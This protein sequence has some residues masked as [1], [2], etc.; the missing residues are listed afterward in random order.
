MAADKRSAH[1]P[2][3]DGLR[4][5][6][7]LIVM[8]YHFT[9]FGGMEPI[10]WTGHVWQALAGVGWTGVDL[11][12]V[13]SGFLITG[14]L[15]DTKGS[16]GYFRIFYIRRTLRIFPLYYGTLALFYIVLPGLAPGIA[17][18]QGAGDEQLW[19]WLYLSNLQIATQG[20]GGTS[21][22]LA[23]FWSL[24]VEEQFYLFWPF[25]VLLLSRRGLMRLCGAIV[26]L[27]LLLRTAF[28]ITGYELAAYVLTPARMD[29]L[30]IGAWIAL[31]F[32]DQRDRARMVSRARSTAALATLALVLMFAWRG[33]AKYHDAV[34]GTLGFT[35]LAL[36]YGSLLVLACV[37][38]RLAKV[39]EVKP[40]RFFGRYSYALYVFHQPIVLEVV[41]AGVSVAAFPVILGSRV[42]AQLTF[43]ALGIA[44]STGLALLSWSL[45]ESPFLRLKKRFNY[46]VARH[47]IGHEQARAAGVP[48]A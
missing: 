21:A 9:I 39:F 30:A 41:A 22:H 6:A 19:N 18:A 46:S 47:S 13:L 45:L 42:P 16:D 1:I 34:I 36:L 14:I 28:H 7:V 32:R 4:G 35:T 17:P 29:A 20:W 27:S 33:T 5:V 24:S 3:L 12:F 44:A 48:A 10:S 31:A 15:Y 2:A 37:E 25:I 43:A 26:V 40:L 8:L 11:F 38:P 23:H